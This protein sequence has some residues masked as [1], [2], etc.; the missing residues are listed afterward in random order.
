MRGF[1]AHCKKDQLLATELCMRDYVIKG[2]VYT[3]AVG[4]AICPHCLNIVPF[5]TLDRH[6]RLAA[7]NAYRSA[8][9]L[10][11]GSQIVAAR[12]IYGLSQRG[13]SRV[14]G[15]GPSCSAGWNS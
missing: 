5:P 6:Q 7:C 3:V 14:L 13:M 11:T 2:E 1:C 15:W 8:H 10:L 9:G 4:V 12:T